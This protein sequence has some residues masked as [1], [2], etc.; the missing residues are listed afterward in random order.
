MFLR[1]QLSHRQCK[2]SLEA[3]PYRRVNADRFQ[4]RL[5]AR[6]VFRPAF[7]PVFQFR[8]MRRRFPDNRFRFLIFI[9]IPIIFRSFFPAFPQNKYVRYFRLFFQ[10]PC[11]ALPD[12]QNKYIVFFHKVFKFCRFGKNMQR[13]GYRCFLC[14]ILRH[15]KRIGFFQI[16]DR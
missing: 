10:L 3:S 7:I 4:S 16:A 15:P 9:N 6:S 5:P 1:Q 2:G 13:I 12:Q 8:H 11:G 14:K